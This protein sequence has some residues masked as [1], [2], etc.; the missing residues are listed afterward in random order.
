MCSRTKEE[1]PVY[2]TTTTPNGEPIATTGMKDDNWWVRRAALVG[3]PED[4]TVDELKKEID[5]RVCARACGC[6]ELLAL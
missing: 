6:C 1:L 2:A 5:V 4:R 3:Y